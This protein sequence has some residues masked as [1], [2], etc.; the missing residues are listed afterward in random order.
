MAHRAGLAFVELLEHLPTDRLHSKVAGTVVVTIDQTRLQDLLSAAGIDTGERVS[1]GEA[2]RIACNAGILPAVLGGK[3]VPI[4]LGRTRRLF[5]ETQQIA[6][7]LTHQT[8][9]ADGCERPFAWCELH[10]REP[11]ALDGET[12]L[13]NGLPLCG[14]HHRRIH[15]NH[16]THRYQTNGRLAFHRRT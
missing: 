1:A 10:H 3:S 6:L 11:W 14:F 13:A 5:T 7:G 2:R 4:D 16:Y 15:D 12:D 9:A 8:C